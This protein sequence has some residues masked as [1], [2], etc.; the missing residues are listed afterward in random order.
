V[1]ALKVAKDAAERKALLRK[2]RR[3]IEEADHFLEESSSRDTVNSSLCPAI[4]SHSSRRSSTKP[5]M[6]DF[7]TSM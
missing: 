6:R 2:M 1:Q 5:I 4:R 3:L 7:K